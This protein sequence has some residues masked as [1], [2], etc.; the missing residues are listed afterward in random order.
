MQPFIRHLVLFGYISVLLLCVVGFSFPPD[1]DP[2]PV[3]KQSGSLACCA[4]ISLAPLGGL[5][6]LF[7]HLTIFQG[8]DSDNF[9]R[10]K[11]WAILVTYPAGHLVHHNNNA[12]G[13]INH[14]LDIR[15]ILE[16]IF[17]KNKTI[18]SFHCF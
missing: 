5:P 10:G 14:R 17:R 8:Y 11:Q 12:T 6:H 1:E 9:T 7:N 2:G 4:P 18:F 13:G 15:M 3:C 16:F